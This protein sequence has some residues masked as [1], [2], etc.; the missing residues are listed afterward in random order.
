MELIQ[1]G[2][3]EVIVRVSRQ[4]LHTVN[5]ALNEVCN[6]IDV[7]EF[8]TRMGV[9][10]EQAKSLLSS[11][12]LILDE[13]TRRAPSET[14]SAFRDLRISDGEV[15]E[16]VIRGGGVVVRLQDWQGHLIAVTFD[17]VIAFEG[18]AAIGVDLSHVLESADDP[19]IQTACR[20]EGESPEGYFCFS[21]IS[22]WTDEP[23]L[24]IVAR[25]AVVADPHY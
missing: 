3:D 18:I 19:L 6:G 15:T 13:G 14:T 9:T 25:R 12:H 7:P 10:P 4:D 8:E 20:Q 22:A 5:N 24:K 2:Q 23:L 1:A 17:D 11:V 16:V 21:L